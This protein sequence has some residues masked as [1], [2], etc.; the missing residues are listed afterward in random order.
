MDNSNGFTRREFMGSS[1]RVVAYTTALAGIEFIVNGCVKEEVPVKEIPEKQ[2]VMVL[3]DEFT[4]I[5]RRRW[6]WRV[7]GAAY[8]YLTSEGV[9]L[10]LKATAN[11]KFYSIAEFYN[12]TNLFMYNFAQVRLKNDNLGKGSRGWGFWNGSMDINKIKTAWFARFQGPE[13]YFLNGFYAITTT[14]GKSRRTRV[15]DI[16]LEDWHT[17]SIDWQKDRVIF[18]IDDVPVVEHKADIPKSNMQFDVWL[19]NSVYMRKGDDIRLIYQNIGK[20][21]SLQVD[22]L[23]ILKLAEP[24]Q[25][26]SQ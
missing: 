15:K 17:Y 4:G 19:D 1:A 8:H 6:N 26:Q 12:P 5:D 18:W 22:N 14:F 16:S 25:P 13:N 23:T 24:Y 9:K 10:G 3:K 2:N 7:G 20:E 11:D 21:T